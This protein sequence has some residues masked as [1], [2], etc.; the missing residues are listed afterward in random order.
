M[1]LITFT[2]TLTNNWFSSL[3]RWGEQLFVQQLWFSFM[4]LWTGSCSR[5]LLAAAHAGPLYSFIIPTG[6]ADRP[7]QTGVVSIALQDYIKYAW[8]SLFWKV[9]MNLQRAAGYL[10]ISVKDT[11]NETELSICFSPFTLQRTNETFYNLFVPAG[12]QA[13]YHRHVPPLL[14][15]QSPSHLGRGQDGT[16]ILCQMDTAIRS[17]NWGKSL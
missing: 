16:L 5:S 2:S 1:H 8:D 14:G 6:R 13:H 7:L 17:I 15:F 9:N 10:Y 3:R 12:F 11:F 4:V